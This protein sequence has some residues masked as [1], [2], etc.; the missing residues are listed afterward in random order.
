MIEGVAGLIG[1]LAAFGGVL[2]GWA[3]LNTWRQQLRGTVEYDLARRV[4]RV[5]L[6][7]RDQIAAIRNPVASLTEI[8]AAHRESGAETAQV[9]DDPGKDT[10]LMYER[11]FNALRQARSELAIELLEAEVLWGPD[12]RQAERE[13]GKCVSELWLAVHRH[14]REQQGRGRPEPDEA[15]ERRQAVLYQTSDDPAEDKFSG[16]VQEV[17]KRFEYLLRPHIGSH[18]RL[19]ARRRLAIA[20]SVRKLLKQ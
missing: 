15:W 19:P 16:E 9:G 18:R 13:L 5:V 10:Q 6:K 3:G 11:R 20:G 14:V 1:A 7:V 4:L 8:E 2:V 17:V 12:L